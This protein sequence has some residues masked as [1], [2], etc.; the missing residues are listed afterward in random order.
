[1]HWH[2]VELRHGLV[3][4]AV[5]LAAGVAAIFAGYAEKLALNAQA[6]QYDRMRALFERAYELLPSTIAPESFR[7]AQALFAE[8][9]AEAMKETAGW[10]EI[11]RQ[12]P[13]R[14]P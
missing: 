5:G 8:L 2:Q 14:P 6:R 13:I 3:I 9:G 10:V 1:M 4:L 12:R 7:R 11:Y